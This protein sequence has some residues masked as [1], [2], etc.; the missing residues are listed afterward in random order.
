MLYDDSEATI[1]SVQERSCA[2]RSLV[3]G[4]FHPVKNASRN[5]LAES[6]QLVDIAPLASLV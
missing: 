1:C 2:S 4:F 3:E 5:D 6:G